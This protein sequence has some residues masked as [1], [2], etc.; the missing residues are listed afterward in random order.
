MTRNTQRFLET[1]FKAAAEAISKLQPKE[2]TMT[3]CKSSMKICELCINPAFSKM[4]T[5]IGQRL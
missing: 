2:D 4:I 3:V 5:H 1:A